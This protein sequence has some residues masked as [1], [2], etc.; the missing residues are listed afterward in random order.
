MKFGVSMLL[1][2]I[3]SFAAGLYLPFWSAGLVAFLV[4]VFIYQKPVPFTRM[5]A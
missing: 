2:I 3:V 1:T 5:D 4:S